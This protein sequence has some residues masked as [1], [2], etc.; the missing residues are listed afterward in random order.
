MKR[1][2]SSAAGFDIDVHHSK[3]PPSSSSSSPTS[4]STRSS[5]AC[6]ALQLDRHPGLR[7]PGTTVLT[8][9]KGV[10]FGAR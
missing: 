7:R 1:P 9:G 5:S 6:D 4:G 10:E 3:S 2:S 8:E